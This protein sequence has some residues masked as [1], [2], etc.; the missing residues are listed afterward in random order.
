MCVCFSDLFWE[1]HYDVVKFGDNVAMEVT[2]CELP[3]YPLPPQIEDFIKK[4]KYENV[5]NKV[6]RENYRRRMH[7]LL[8]LE[9]FQQRVGLSRSGGGVACGVQSLVGVV[10]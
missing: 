9:E 1:R 5:E 3:E 2:D 6:T 7:N 4:G 10:L 8:Y